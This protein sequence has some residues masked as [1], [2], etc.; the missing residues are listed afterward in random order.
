MRNGCCLVV[1]ECLPG[2]QRNAIDGR[3]GPL[4]YPLNDLIHKVG[5]DTL[6]IQPRMSFLYEL[7]SSC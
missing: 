3:L 4:L 2:Q 6:T 5:A 1:A 7:A